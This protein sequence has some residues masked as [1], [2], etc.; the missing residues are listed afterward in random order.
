MHCFQTTASLR[1][2]LVLRLLY[3]H[4][5]QLGTTQHIFFD[6]VTS[7]QHAQYLLLAFRILIIFLTLVML[8]THLLQHSFKY[9]RLRSVLVISCLLSSL[10]LHFWQTFGNSSGTDFVGD[11]ISA[12]LILSSHFMNDGYGEALITSD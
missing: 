3:N 7:L 10:N 12:Q 4:C 5:W 11:C 8:L 6:W 2:H 9:M 1:Y